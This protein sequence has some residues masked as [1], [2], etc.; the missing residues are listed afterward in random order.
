MNNRLLSHNVNPQDLATTLA[1][2]KNRIRQA[3]DKPHVTV[4]R[5]LQIVDELAQ[6]EFGQF[7]L[8]HNGVN[9][10]WT[11]YMTT[12]PWYGGKTGLSSN[13]KP[14]T[15]MEKFF[16]EKTMVVTQQRFEH[17]LKENQRA[18]KNNAK[19]ACIPSGMMG[20]LLYLDF[21]GID[22][23]ELIGID[24]D[25]ETL[26]DA[27]Q[28]AQ[29]RNVT[30]WTKFLCK[31]AWHLAIENELDLISSNGL[32]IYEPD[33]AK[34]MA[35]YQQFYNAL[36]PNGILVTSFLTFSPMFADQCK[37]DMQKIDAETSLIQRI[38]F[39]DI[40]EAKFNCYRSE[41]QIHE[42]LQTIGFKDIRFIY[43]E[44]KVFPTVVAR[45]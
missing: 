18:V 12:Y 14:L 6:F 1:A 39:V 44:A 20:E 40:L 7:L 26:E 41:E 29:K 38:I 2:I 35:L 22:Q 16:L 25:P 13:G 11:H 37:W 32:T 43:D 28:L 5:Q 42:Q 17:F 33:E 4:Q 36:V 27:K 10:Y 15:A 30:Q 45:K 24:Y 3:G 31:D 19:L 34:I 8:Q 23:I 21:S 9:G